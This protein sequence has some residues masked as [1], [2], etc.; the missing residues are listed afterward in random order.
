VPEHLKNGLR[1]Y[2]QHGYIPGDFL[3]AVLRNDLKEAI[4][5]GDH[6]SI[7]GLRGLVVFLY[8]YVPTLCQGSKSAMVAWAKLSEE[9][10]DRIWELRNQEWPEAPPPPPPHHTITT[11]REG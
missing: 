11:V 5:R 2:L 9:E 4:S 7:M 3:Q 1:L 10:R 6:Y 8:N